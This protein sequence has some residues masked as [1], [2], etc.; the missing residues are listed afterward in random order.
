MAITRSQRARYLEQ[1]RALFKTKT[2]HVIRTIKDERFEV[3][4]NLQDYK[5]AFY[6]KKSVDFGVMMC[7]TTRTK[8]HRIA[9]D[10]LKKMRNLDDN[11]DIERL[12]KLIRVHANQLRKIGTV[13]AQENIQMYKSMLESIEQNLQWLRVIKM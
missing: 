8:I 11:V 7:L 6:G 10:A 12:P 1:Q 4:D 13:H 9:L 5:K 2:N 3:E